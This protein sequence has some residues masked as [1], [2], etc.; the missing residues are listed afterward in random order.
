MS[1]VIR[2]NMMA[3]AARR[4]L[5]STYGKMSESVKALSSGLRINSADDD[6]AGL[7]VR[8]GM[9]AKVAALEQGVRNG[10]DAISMLQTFDGAA[11]VIDEK[12]VRMKQLA[13]QAATGTYTSGQRNIMNQEFSELKSEI[14]RIANNTEFNGKKALDADSSDALTIHFGPDSGDNYSID[15]HNL[16][17]TG[18]GLSATSITTASA[19]Q[20]ALNTIDN[21]IQTKDSARAHFGAMTNRLRATV[22]AEQIRRE[23]LQPADSRI[24]DVDVA[25]EMAK[26]TRNKVL[27]QSG[28]AMLAQANS[29]PQM[30]MSL[31]R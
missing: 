29:V 3:Q 28:V 24:S 8:E 1:L 19:A 16:T 17:A 15:K 9:R 13:E 14:S 30:A 26:L 23:N 27:A 2:H 11:G 7:A 31:L 21:A 4:Q 5:G 22:S 18:L 12:L 25:T 10:N 6:A 20:T